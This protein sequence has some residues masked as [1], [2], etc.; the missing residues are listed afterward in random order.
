MSLPHRY[1]KDFSPLSLLYRWISNLQL[2][3]IHR[4]LTLSLFCMTSPVW[5]GWILSNIPLQKGFT[6]IPMVSTRTLPKWEIPPPQ[7]A[8]RMGAFCA[9]LKPFFKRHN[10][11]EDPCG[12]VAWRTHYHSAQGNPLIYTEFGT[13][14][15]TTLFFGGVHPDELTPIQ[16]SF[17]LAQHLHDHPEI[18]RDKDIRIIVAPLINPDGAFVSPPIRTNRTI[19][20]NR[21]FLTLDW[22]EKAHASWQKKNRQPR[23]FPGFFPNSEIETHFQIFLM[24]TYQPTK[25]LSMHSPLGF[26]DYDG[27]EED[28]PAP[29]GTPREFIYTV[30]K[31]SNNYKVVNYAIFPGSL[32]TFAGYERNVP[33]ITLE[34]ETNDTTKVYAYWK[35]FFPGFLHSIQHTFSTPTLS[36]RKK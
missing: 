21:N 1:R 12:Q 28:T 3:R 10:W 4:F 13:G 23:F 17:R 14:R 9:Q 8:A 5:A 19:D 31:K 33:T 24:N 34:L 30:A 25:I 29:G 6:K 15:N 32:G 18:Y 7:Q 20:V 16:L 35:Q 26:Y 36:L 2:G 11:K 27:P 22:Y